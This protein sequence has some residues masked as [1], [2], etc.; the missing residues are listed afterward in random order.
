MGGNFDWLKMMS[1]SAVDLSISGFLANQKA[2]F[3]LVMCWNQIGFISSLVKTLRLNYNFLFQRRIIT[4]RKTSFYTLQVFFQWFNLTTTLDWAKATIDL[5]SSLREAKKT[6]F[7]DRTKNMPMVL[8]ILRHL[9]R[10]KNWA[11]LSR[12]ITWLFFKI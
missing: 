9:E 11:F 12:K 2:Q 4:L 7:P 5:I 3:E 6:R 1:L 8:F 10:T